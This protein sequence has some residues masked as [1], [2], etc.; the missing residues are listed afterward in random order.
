VLRYGQR[1][2]LDPASPVYVPISLEASL[3]RFL[4]GFAR[5]CTTR[6]RRGGMV[7]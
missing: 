4:T 5:N 1:A 6:R 3:W 7:T 2:A